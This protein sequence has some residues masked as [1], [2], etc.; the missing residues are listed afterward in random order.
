[1]SSVDAN[2][3]QQA[4]NNIYN[5]GNLESPIATFKWDPNNIKIRSLT[6]EKTLEPLVTQV[7]T[8]VNKTGPSDLRKGQSKRAEVLVATMEKATEIFILKGQEIASENPAMAGELYAAIEDVRQTGQTMSL[9]SRK[10]AEDPCSSAKRAD[11]VKAARPLL[12]AVTRLLIVA[13]M[14]DVQRLLSSVKV[15]EN[16][17]MNLKNAFSQ[18]E[19]LD[20][21]DGSALC[22]WRG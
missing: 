14:I 8:L 9:M 7:T 3:M 21:R 16:D 2:K 18:Q 13:D 5:N 12:L 22:E 6:V 17:L 20:S 10:F 19:V 4:N 1:M 15:V 11:I